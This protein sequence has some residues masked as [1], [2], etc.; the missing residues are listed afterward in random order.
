MPEAS[1]CAFLHTFTRLDFERVRFCR[2]LHTYESS[3]HLLCMQKP[4]KPGVL[5]RHANERMQKRAESIP[6]HRSAPLPAPRT[7]CD[8]ERTRSEDVDGDVHEPCRCKFTPQTITR[9]NRPV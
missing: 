7:G 2:F 5:R 6:Q 8:V 3:S 4:A 9:H 1:K